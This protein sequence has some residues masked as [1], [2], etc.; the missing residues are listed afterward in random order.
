LGGDCDQYD[1]VNDVEDYGVLNFDPYV[2]VYALVLYIDDYHL[3]ENS[4]DIFL[5]LKDLPLQTR[6]YYCL[7]VPE[8]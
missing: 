2:V 8:S 4:V 1:E 5:V 3:V 7:L 6:N